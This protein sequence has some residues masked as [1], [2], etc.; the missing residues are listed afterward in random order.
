MY[1]NAVPAHLD[2]HVAHDERRADGGLRRGVWVIHGKFGC[3]FKIPGEWFSR[4]KFSVYT[5]P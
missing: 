4:R 2:V 1:L 3:P 5:F